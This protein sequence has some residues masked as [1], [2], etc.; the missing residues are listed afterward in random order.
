MDFKNKF[1]L[2]DEAHLLAL[3]DEDDGDGDDDG[4]DKNDSDDENDLQKR[5]AMRRI[6]FR[7]VGASITERL[8]ES[9]FRLS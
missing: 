7:P 8:Q 9:S 3:D 4:E 5:Q 1:G 2:V 6:E